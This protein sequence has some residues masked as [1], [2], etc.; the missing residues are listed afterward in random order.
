MAT[1][2]VPD[3]I[4]AV[5]EPLL[6]HL[7]TFEAAGRA[8]ERVDFRTDERVM[9]DLVATLEG[10]CTGRMLESLDMG[11]PRVRVGGQTYRKMNNAM[12]QKTY[13]GMRAKVLV[14]RHLFRLEGVRNGPTIVPMEL[15]AGIV[16][17]VLTPAAAEG[18]AALGHAMPSREASDTSARLGVLPYSRSEHFR[19]AV[20]VGQ[21][22]GELRELYEETLVETMDLPEQLAA[23][24]VAVD[25]VSIPMR[26]PRPL[27]D[28]DRKEGIKNPVAVNL[29]MAFCSV[30]TLY[31]S[32]G[33][34]LSSIRYAHVPTGGADDMKVVLRDDLEVLLRRRPG[35]P[36]VGL[37]DG[38]ADMQSILD[39]VLAG[40]IAGSVVDL[41]HVLEKLGEAAMAVD[42]G[43]GGHVD[44]WRAELLQRDDAVI[45]IARELAQWAAPYAEPGIASDLP[46]RPEALHAAITY[47]TN[48]GHRMQYAS[49]HAA[50]LP[51]GSGTVEATGKTIMGTRMRRPGC[52]WIEPGA[53][54]ILA[55]RALGTSMQERWHNVM[56]Y[57]T[58]SYTAAVEPLQAK[59]RKGVT[60]GSM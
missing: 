20:Q 56:E 37:A 16:E 32:S 53:Q 9:M 21:R 43:A 26:E 40:R 45:H 15:R 23:I 46:A 19:A 18:M 51:I 5:L 28:R 35:L 30:V 49:L 10:R 50:G 33:T 14:Q 39:H 36:V 13:F 4:A 41:W 44:R 12:T 8:G 57:V 11:C 42:Q 3:D 1:I 25:R 47:L 22:W 38:A 7:A 34:P 6:Q 2:E 24:S 27:T 54:P 55:L 52:Q 17:G 60:V 29:R 59:T 48:L 58:H 31:D